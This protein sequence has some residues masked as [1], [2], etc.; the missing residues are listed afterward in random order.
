MEEKLVKIL[1]LINLGFLGEIGLVY[2]LTYWQ[3][4]YI[5]NFSQ[6]LCIICH[7]ETDS[8]ALGSGTVISDWLYMNEA[9]TFWM[10]VPPCCLEFV[11][12]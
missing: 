3:T 11:Q 2:R 10:R 9:K 12:L 6:V 7:V 8:L 1:P 4:P 5:L